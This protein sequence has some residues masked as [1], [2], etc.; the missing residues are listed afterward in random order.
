M[1]KKEKRLKV[2]KDALPVFL[3]GS[4]MWCAIKHKLEIE[5]M[6]GESLWLTLNKILELFET[7]LHESDQKQKSIIIA[8]NKMIKRLT[9]KEPENE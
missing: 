2:N 8:Q 1:E 7:Y 9:N 3:A 4:P 5:G 6:K